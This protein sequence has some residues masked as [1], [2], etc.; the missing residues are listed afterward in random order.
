M[1]DNDSDDEQVDLLGEENDLNKIKMALKQQLPG[2]NPNSNQPLQM[3]QGGGIDMS[4]IVP[5]S[6]IG[7]VMHTMQDEGDSSEEEQPVINANF[8]F[9]TGITVPVQNN[10]N[11][12]DSSDGGEYPRPNNHNKGATT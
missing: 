8:N 4:R 7:T 1:L 9:G 2:A 11:D 5:R 6:G 12:S 3:G 10:N